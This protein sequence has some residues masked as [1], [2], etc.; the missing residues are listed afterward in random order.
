MANIT[1]SSPALQTKR[2]VEGIAGDTHTLLAVAQQNDIPVPFKCEVGDCASCLIKVTVLEDHAPMAGTLSEKEKYTLA[3]HGKLSKEAQ[4]LA[5][6]ADIMPHYR[7]ACQYIV[8]NENILVEFSGKPGVEIDPDRQKHERATPD[9]IE[10]TG[11]EDQAYAEF[12][13]HTEPGTATALGAGPNGV[14]SGGVDNLAV[15]VAHH[16]KPTIKGVEAGHLA[17]MVNDGQVKQR[18]PE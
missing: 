16:P 6:T 3:A 4:K 17:G 7:L 12:Q 9:E 8:R 18:V 5:E 15:N 1:F 10:T 11:A 13:S 2:T 14:E